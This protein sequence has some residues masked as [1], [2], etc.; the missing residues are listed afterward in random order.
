MKFIQARNRFLFALLIISTCVGCD[1]TTKHLAQTNLPIYQ[2]FSYLGDT[3]RLQYVLNSGAAFSLGASLPEGVRWWIFVVGQGVFLL[4]LTMYLAKNHNLRRSQFYGFALIL[5]GGLG[6][7]YDRI[8]RD[9]AVVDFLNI[10][11]G[12][13]LRTAIFNVADIAITCGLVLL[14]IGIYKNEDRKKQDML[15][16]TNENPQDDSSQQE[17]GGNIQKDDDKPTE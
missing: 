13:F 14:V 6:N 8:F 9:G 3:I 12:N 10:G 15:I 1:Q 17:T 16:D 4:F 7:F 5:G 11:I 2:M